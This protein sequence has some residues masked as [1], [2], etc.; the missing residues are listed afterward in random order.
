MTSQPTPSEGEPQ[1]ADTPIVPRIDKDVIETIRMLRDTDPLFL[2]HELA[3][4]TETDAE[5]ARHIPAIADYFSQLVRNNGYPL[6]DALEEIVFIVHRSGIVQGVIEGTPPLDV[7][8]DLAG[9]DQLPSHPEPP[10]GPI[11]A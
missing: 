11:A 1:S 8:D 4:L 6:K 5:L 2:T 7:P 3:K 10:D 9:I